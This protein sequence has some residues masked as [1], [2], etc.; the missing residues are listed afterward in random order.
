MALDLAPLLPTV[1]RITAKGSKVYIH[2]F[3]WPG[4]EICIAGV[5]NTVNSA[6]LLTTGEEVKVVQEQDRVFLRGLPRLPPDPYDTV[7]V[8]ELDSKPKGVPYTPR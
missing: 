7:I 5:G 8:L 3:R 4:K 1:G 2:A 6:Y